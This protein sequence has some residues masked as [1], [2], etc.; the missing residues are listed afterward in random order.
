MS[1]TRMDDDERRGFLSSAGPSST[2]AILAAAS[3]YREAV[4]AA[5]QARLALVLYGPTARKAQKKADRLVAAS[6]SAALAEA[7]AWRALEAAC[8]GA[9][10][11]SAEEERADA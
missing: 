7:E 4:T 9:G 8:G 2:A 10:V 3:K 11:S 1:E 6:V 5:E